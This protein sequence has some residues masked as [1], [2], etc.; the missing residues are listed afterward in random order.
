MKIKYERD[1]LFYNYF[2]RYSES[3]ENSFKINNIKEINLPKP[4]K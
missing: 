4:K 2:I 1:T 3:D